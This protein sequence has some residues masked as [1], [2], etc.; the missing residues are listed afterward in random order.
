MPHGHSAIDSLIALTAL[1][2]YQEGG[3]VEDKSATASIDNL[4]AD[5][6]LKKEWPFKKRSLRSHIRQAAGQL[7]ELPIFENKYYDLFKTPLDKFQAL[8]P[9]GGEMGWRDDS[10]QWNTVDSKTLQKLWRKAGAPM[11]EVRDTPRSMAAPRE[12]AFSDAPNKLQQ[13][14]GYLFGVPRVI[15]A[16]GHFGGERGDAGDVVSEL[17]HQIHFEDPKKYGYT[18]KSMIEDMYKSVTSRE[19]MS[20]EEERASVYDRPG[21]MEYLA[22]R[23]I[24][25]RLLDWIKQNY[26]PEPEVAHISGPLPW[27][28]ELKKQMSGKLGM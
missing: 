13:A 4:I 26:V 3:P 10:G 14:M 18:R 22:H 21:T 28:E 15:Q 25:P 2:K 23:E 12:F 27:Q 17:A 9:E 24:E 8:F 16:R 1:R 6:E 11:I 5:N 20:P 19:G 7:S